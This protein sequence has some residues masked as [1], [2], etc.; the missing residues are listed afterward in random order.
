MVFFDP[1]VLPVGA[2]ITQGR[3]TLDT[4]KTI[5]DRFAGA[6]TVLGL[7]NVSFGLPARAILN[8]AFLHMALYAGLDAAIADPLD[9]DLMDAV[10]TGE[11]LL[12]KDR[13]CRRYTRAFRR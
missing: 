6:R 13:H 4:I 1:L 2:D 5:K 11:V 10:K 8:A 9:R 7:S 3:I 12:G